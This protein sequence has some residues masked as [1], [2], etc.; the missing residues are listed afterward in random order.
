[1]A[2]IKYGIRAATLEARFGDAEFVGRIEPPLRSGADAIAPPGA[3]A[4]RFGQLN[5]HL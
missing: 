1:M 4:G 5:K 2:A 3:P